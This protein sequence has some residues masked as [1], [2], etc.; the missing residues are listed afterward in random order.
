M[1][2]IKNSK[3]INENKNKEWH[4]KCNG[5]CVLICGLFGDF[6]NK[7]HC[8]NFSS[9]SCKECKYKDLTF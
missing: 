8:G 7:C 9:K 3:F 6:E 2:L 1:D 5:C 4:D